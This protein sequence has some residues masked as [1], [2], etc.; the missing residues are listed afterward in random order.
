MN[1]AEIWLGAFKNKNVGYW[2]L[3]SK[4][5]PNLKSTPI[6]PKRAIEC[7]YATK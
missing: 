3:N 2:L 6:S 4:E 5:I 7:I 1:I